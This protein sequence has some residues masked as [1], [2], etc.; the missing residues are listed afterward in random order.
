MA[1]SLA[2]IPSWR[3]DE[4]LYS[5]AAGFHA[6]LGNGSSRDTGALLFGAQ[7]ACREHDAPS[8]LQRFVEL[9]NGRLGD[10]HTL[11]RT[12][13]P[14]GI[15]FP[16]LSEERRKLMLD[17]VCGS[18][19]ANWGVHLGMPA[20]SLVA[21]NTLRFCDDC[22]RE[23]LATW[24]LPRWRLPHQLV[25][26]W[27]CTKH[28][29]MLTERQVAS[30]RWSIPTDSYD[31]VQTY[32][33]DSVC[34]ESIYRL[35][36]LVEEVYRAAAVDIEAVR[37]ATFA[38]LR[39]RGIVR[40]SHPL[41]KDSLARWFVGTPISNWLRMLGDSR[42]SLASGSWIYGLLRN[43]RGDHPIKWMLLWCSLFSEKDED[44]TLVQRFLQPHTTP[45]WEPTGQGCLWDVRGSSVPADIQHLIEQSDSLE[46][47][48]RSLGISIFS[49]RKRLLALGTSAGD[50]R[51]ITRLQRR[52]EMAVREIHDYI[53]THPECTRS[54]IH[55]NCKAAVSWIRAN[56]PIV[57]QQAVALVTD[58]SIQQLTL[59]FEA[60]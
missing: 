29:R 41:N 39:E 49:I 9:T 28:R 45:W 58:K 17:K 40:W 36:R 47:A 10:A 35:A 31:T 27:M 6:V 52:K 44:P 60:K 26:S 15:Y 16:F 7:H 5:W 21:A 32:A 55:V 37:Q 53:A 23:D 20:S 11:L 12:R 4:T 59:G 38:G 50:F 30:S 3:G 13:C 2:Y 57:Y 42:K 56:D 51:Q 14:L 33:S 54:S 34:A 46:A 48:A 1:T 8:D 18:G 24:G 19:I 22:V 43:R 25:G